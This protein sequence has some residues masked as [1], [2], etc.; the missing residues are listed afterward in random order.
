MAIKNMSRKLEF[1]LSYSM[2][3]GNSL[4]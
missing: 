3:L 1:L 4:H 2:L